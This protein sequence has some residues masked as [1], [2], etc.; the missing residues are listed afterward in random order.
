MVVKVW[1]SGGDVRYF[2]LELRNQDKS[3]IFISRC[4]LW[5]DE[6]W[7]MI[8]LYRF[9]NQNQDDV[10][11]FLVESFSSYCCGGAAVYVKHEDIGKLKEV[12]QVL[13]SDFNVGQAQQLPTNFE[14]IFKI[15][16]NYDDLFW[17][18]EVEGKKLLVL[19]AKAALYKFS[20]VDI[21]TS[22][23]PAESRFHE[24]SEKSQGL[25]CPVEVQDV[26]HKENNEDEF[27][28]FITPS[29]LNTNDITRVPKQREDGWMEIQVWKF[30]STH[31]FKDDFLSMNMKFT[32]HQGTMSG[33]IICGLEFRPMFS[34]NSDDIQRQREKKNMLQDEVLKVTHSA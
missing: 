34:G 18:G 33:L 21:F 24:L 11:E 4:C 30:N 22:K 15:C 10:F 5:R 1:D 29:P 28:Y 8:E 7:M 9:L 13:K 26:L 16:R 20:N 27:V 6:Q 14:E 17:L 3:S 2:L 23:P 25:H 12:Q 32:R 31:E 19:S